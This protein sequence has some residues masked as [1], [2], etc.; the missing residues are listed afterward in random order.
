MIQDYKIPLPPIDMQN[1]I[2]EEIKQRRDETKK[3]QTE[4][5]E[6]L[7]KAKKDV[8]KIILGDSK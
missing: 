4:A 3:L 1:R 2:A 7:E 8:E 5:K 6:V